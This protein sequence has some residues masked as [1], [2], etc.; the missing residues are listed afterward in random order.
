MDYSKMMHVATGKRTKAGIIGATRGYGYTLLA[1]IPHV[2]QMD[3][4][5]VCSRHPEECAAVLKEIGYKE[6]RMV[7][8]ETREQ[9][10]S[11]PEEAI[12][13]VSDYRLVMECGIT[14]L[15]ECTGNTAVSS[16]AALSALRRGINVYMVSKETDSICGPY[17]NQEAAKNGVV[18]ALV[19]GDQPRNLVDLY[20]WAM[21]LGLEITAAGKASEYDF[22]WDQD[23]Q[24]LTYTDGS[25]RKKQLPG[26]QD[27][28]RYKGKETLNARRELLEDYMEVISADLCEMNLVSNI[29]GLL[30]AAPCLNYPV[31]KVSE[32]AD[33]F[34]P[35]EEGGILKKTGVVDVFCNLREKDEASFCGGEFIIVK[36]ENRKMW[37]LL[38]E[39]GHIVSRNGKY[40]C[41][42]YPYHYMGLETPVSILLGDQMGIGTHPECRQVSILTGAA[43]RDLPRGTVFTVQGHH[44]AI[45]GLTPE[46]L[47]RKEAGHAAPF[48]LL[49]GAVL[50]RDV[51][52]G[53]L[54][55][56][57]DVDLTGLEA[58][59]MYAEGLKQDI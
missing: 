50:K 11:A 52:K 4:R 55:T 51:K 12:L 39:K 58:Y 10:Q 43:D 53:A 14:A 48:Y 34:I 22:V 31:A 20:S 5:A 49:N 40:A 29:T 1:Q 33:I 45:D 47:E 30:P 17:L 7:V 36:C 21:L 35:E 26:M 24:E 8:C 15:V 28:W 18:Y 41:I 56:L 57:E 27:C 59:R 37:D 2:K 25:G 13:I 54:I 38:K 6:E 9:I 42:Y 46:L 32:L 23:S 3:L 16:D 19:N 44:H